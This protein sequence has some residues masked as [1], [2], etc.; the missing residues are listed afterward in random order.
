M[1]LRGSAWFGDEGDDASEKGLRPG[2]VVF[3]VVVEL[4]EL[5]CPGWWEGE[6]FFWPPAVGS[7]R[8]FSLE[9][10]EDFAHVFSCKWGKR[11]SLSRNVRLASFPELSPDLRSLL[12]AGFE[13]VGDA[14]GAWI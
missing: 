10:G 9:S 2:V 4:G 1:R 7:F 6:K 5:V 12:E 14:L 11:G 13:C 3:P 8:F